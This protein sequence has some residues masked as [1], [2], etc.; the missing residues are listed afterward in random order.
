MEG[1]ASA[2]HASAM[3]VE[4]LISSC[5]LRWLGCPQPGPGAE[6]KPFRSTE[7][8]QAP[9]PLLRGRACVRSKC[10][11]SKFD[12]QRLARLSE[13]LSLSGYLHTRVRSSSSQCS[14]PSLAGKCQPSKPGFCHPTP[15]FVRIAILQS[16]AQKLNGT[17]CGR[18]AKLPSGPIVEIGSRAGRKAGLI[19]ARRWEL[20][21]FALK[22]AR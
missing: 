10:K 15:P 20:P 3:H 5:R 13:Q 6:L 1:S 11:G 17:I 14:S 9:F 16:P 4:Q 18:C 2:M 7:Q 8:P 22:M 19:I 21:G 12:R